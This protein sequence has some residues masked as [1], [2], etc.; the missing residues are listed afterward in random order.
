MACPDD[1][2]AERP[3]NYIESIS[4]DGSWDTYGIVIKWTEPI[5]PGNIKLSLNEP[6]RLRLCVETKNDLEVPPEALTAWCWTPIITDENPCGI[7]KEIKLDYNPK[8]THWNDHGVTSYVF[9]SAI[10]PRKTDVYR[11]TFNVKYD[12]VMIWA[13]YFQVDNLL[14]IQ[15]K[16][17]VATQT[18]I[19]PPVHF[20]GFF[21]GK[22]NDQET[23][24]SL[25]NKGPS[26]LTGARKSKKEGADS[27][28]LEMLVM[29]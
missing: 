18:V 27:D 8:C 11:L 14:D 2:E 16:P 20:S 26:E 3:R 12:R 19:F 1:P 21:C 29:L 9:Q 22:S 6:V 7:W 23:Q 28:D 17:S 5:V 13:N 4:G 10:V 24:R 15:L 25:Q